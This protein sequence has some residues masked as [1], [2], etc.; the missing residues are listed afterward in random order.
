MYQD[1]FYSH[2]IMFLVFIASVV[3]IG[4]CGLQLAV[5][6]KKKSLFNAAE[7][8]HTIWHVCLCLHGKRMAVRVPLS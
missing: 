6:K 3:C 4:V 8:L 7:I 5:F 1:K 2:E